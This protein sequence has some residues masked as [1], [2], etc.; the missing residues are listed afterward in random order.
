M[1]DWKA[2]RLGTDQ[3]LELYNLK[4]DVAEKHDVARENARIVARIQDYLKTART[5]WD[6]VPAP[7]SGAAGEHGKEKGM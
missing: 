5:D 2:V 6:R 3:P 1:A 7:P 4:K